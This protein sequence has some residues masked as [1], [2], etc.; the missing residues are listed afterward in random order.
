LKVDRVNNSS[1]HKITRIIKCYTISRIG[2]YASMGEK[3]NAYSV[4]WGNLKE[5]DHVED[6]GVDGMVIVKWNK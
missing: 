3:R 1:Q 5:R 6:L 4:S 2:K